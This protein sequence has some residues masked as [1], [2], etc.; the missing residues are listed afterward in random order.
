MNPVGGPRLPNPGAPLPT[1][2]GGFNVQVGARPAG[3]G[4]EIGQFFPVTQPGLVTIARNVM[5]AIW[6]ILRP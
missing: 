2:A 1:T 5:R 4:V 3:G 6:D